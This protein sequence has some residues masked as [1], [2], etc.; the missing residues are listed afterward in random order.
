MTFHAILEKIK[1]KRGNFSF[2]YPLAIRLAA[3]ILAATDLVCTY[4]SDGFRAL[5]ACLLLVVNTGNYGNH[6]HT[7]SFLHTMSNAIYLSRGDSRRKLHRSSGIFN[8]LPQLP[9]KHYP[10]DSLPL[11]SEENIERLEAM[12]DAVDQLETNMT[13]LAEMHT[14]VNHRFNEPFAAFLYGLLMTMFC[15]NFPGCPTQGAFESI[16]KVQQAQDRVSDLQKRIQLARAANKALQ[17]EVTSKTLEHKTMALRTDAFARKTPLRRRRI[18]ISTPS[19]A[20]SRLLKIQVA[21]DDTFSTTDSFIETPAGHSRKPQ[22]PRAARGPI[23][24]RIPNIAAGGP[25]LD[26]PPRYMRGLFDKTNTANI[27]K[28]ENKR[29]RPASKTGRLV[30][31]PPFR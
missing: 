12:A 2:I 27:R 13:K 28:S 22:I 29:P 3:I 14:A 20:P 15:N 25:N 17:E 6:K 7:L 19:A 8:M 24:S 23:D 16:N 4:K 11:E 21:Q 1:I 30:S 18:P 31:R 10:E 5:M 26:Q 9:Q